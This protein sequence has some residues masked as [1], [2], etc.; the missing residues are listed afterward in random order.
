MNV[1]ATLFGQ[2]LV[3]ALLIWFIKAFLWEPMRNVME[4][5]KKRIA[6]GLAA[7]ERGQK[8]QE[9]AEQQVRQQLNAAKQQAS[10]IISQA[11]RR[12][13]EIVEEAKR[14]AREEGERI[15]AAAQS[16]IEQEINRAREGLRKQVAMISIAAAEQVLKKEID[17][18]AH[19][20]VLDDLAAQI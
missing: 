11:Q 7:A 18:K 3:F 6:D 9:E 15:K 8:E 10:E 20:A 19:S 1:T 5:R 12:A 2:I 4:N 13:S 17:A 14:E 16:D